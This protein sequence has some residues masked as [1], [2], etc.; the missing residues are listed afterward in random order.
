MEGIYI[1]SVFKPNPFSSGTWIEFLHTH[2]SRHAEEF[3]ED[4]LAIARI[5]KGITYIAVLN[6]LQFV[7]G[8][9]F[10]NILSKNLSPAEIG[11]FSTL[12]FT[13]TVLSVLAPLALQIAAVK[14][15]AE[16]LGREDYEKAAAVA[17]T[18]SRMVLF[19]SSIF[20]AI[21]LVI[22]LVAGQAWADIEGIEML[23]AVTIGAGFLAA[24]RMTY[25]SLIQGLQ[26]F[27][28][29]AIA[30]LS[31][32]T[33]VRFLGIL[34]VLMGEGLLGVALGTLFGEFAGLA[35]TF[36]MY[37]GRLPA[38][39]TQ[40]D[41]KELLK[42]SL[43]ILTMLLVATMQDWSDRMLFL[44]VSG[45]LEALGVFDLAIRAVTSL[46]II[47]A[48]LDVVVLP[49]FSESYGR[50]GKQELSWMVARALRYLGLMYFPAAFG[51]SSISRTAMTVLYQAKLASEG[52]APL[53]ILSIFSI[54]NAFATIMNSSL[55]SIGKTSSFI[56]ISL[57]ALAVDALIVTT[58]SPSLGL[59]GA[60]IARAASILVVFFYMLFELRKELP[61]T[62]D[63]E[64][65]LKGLVAGLSLVPPT[66]FVEYNLSFSSIFVKLGVEVTVAVVCYLLA[67]LFIKAIRKE[68]IDIIRQISPRSMDKI[69][70][71]IERLYVR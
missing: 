27:D 45:N 1:V 25:L 6:A 24:L 70:G 18:T 19:S 34:F 49:T 53:T 40:F 11:I 14:Y 61:F 15:V 54:L 60:I 35:L 64:G 28:K 38:T 69:I 8:I 20:F 26:L 71:L 51:L 43:P 13:H 2:W 46:G 31:S 3:G 55:K 44:A 58:L 68:D 30:N 62:I 63:R 22:A 16:Y 9:I 36:F 5:G 67:L 66:L 59:Y 33:A 50:N 4:I 21:F 48:V 23:L 52:N 39:K 56:R 42:F 10:Y 57:S 7:V 12:T 37:R 47:G 17:R 32:M 65:L 29:Y 41:A